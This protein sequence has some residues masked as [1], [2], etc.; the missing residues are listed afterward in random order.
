MGTGSKRENRNTAA[1]IQ[2]V[3]GDCMEH[4]RSMQRRSV[5]HVFSDIPFAEVNRPSGSA[6]SFDKGVAD[7]ST[8]CTEEFAREAIRLTRG[9]V[10]VFCGSMQVS[11]LMRVFREEGLRMVRVGTAVKTA[12]SPLNGQHGFVS[13][14]ESLVIGKKPRTPFYG[15]CVPPVFPM[16]PVHWRNRIHKTEKPVSTLREI[17][18]LVS[19][20]GDLILDPCMGSGAVGVAATELKRRFLGIELDAAYFEAA[21]RRLHKR[22]H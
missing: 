20:E 12:P 14:T 11:T 9:W 3:H 7:V 13:G 5:D 6:R 8:F 22:S 16:P 18:S 1:A 2:L 21:R 19:A 4:M 10:L 17:L 15:H